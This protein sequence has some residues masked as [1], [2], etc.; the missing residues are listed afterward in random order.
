MP[1]GTF[2][3][4]VSYL[5]TS[6]K[7]KTDL[8]HHPSLISLKLVACMQIGDKISKCAS[9]HLWTP[10][11]ITDRRSARTQT[12]Y[13]VSVRSVTQPGLKPSVGNCA[14]T[15]LVILLMSIILN[16]YVP[17]SVCTILNTRNGYRKVTYRPSCDECEIAE[18]SWTTLNSF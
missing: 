15:G 1:S 2:G 11:Y 18:F 16:T 13:R 4:F 7:F 6:D 8:S 17:L 3:N 5:H 12:T 10:V 14:R 9:S